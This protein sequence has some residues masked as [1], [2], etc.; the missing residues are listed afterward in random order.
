MRIATNG[1]IHWNLSRQF[2]TAPAL[3]EEFIE[4]ETQELKNRVFVVPTEPGFIITLGNIA[5]VER[6]LPMIAEPGML[7]HI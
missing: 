7:D 2:A 3:N 5:T 1:L 6:A 4:V